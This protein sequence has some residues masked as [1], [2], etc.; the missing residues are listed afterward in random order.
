MKKSTLVC[1]LAALCVSACGGTTV[2]ETLGIDKRAPDEFRVV[3]RP[4]LS[5]PPQFDLRPPGA[6]GG[7]SYEQ[8]EKAESLVLGSGD[9]P[10]A[11]GKKTAKSSS[12]ADNLFLQN[13]GAQ[14]ADPNVKKELNEKKIEEQL[15]T[16]EKGWW[17]KITLSPDSKEPVV[18]PQAEAERIQKNKQEGKPVTEGKTAESGGG[19]MST[20][21]HW[22]GDW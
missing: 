7:T 5:V 1:T 2:K 21:E 12:S 3:S 22:F 16:E 6:D 4:P 18:K 13:A 17:D 10:A 19:V 11:N 14:V 8:R 15:K 9:K 20:L